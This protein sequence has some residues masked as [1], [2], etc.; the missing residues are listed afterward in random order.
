MILQIGDFMKQYIRLYE[1]KHRY[2]HMSMK[3]SI[4]LIA[5]I[6]Y[7]ANFNDFSI[8]NVSLIDLNGKVVDADKPSKSIQE[9]LKY[10]KKN[11][12]IRCIIGKPDNINFYWSYKDVEEITL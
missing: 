7:K 4:G 5:F 6:K 10:Y 12:N 9:H 2:I 8:S 11:E 3:L 1:N